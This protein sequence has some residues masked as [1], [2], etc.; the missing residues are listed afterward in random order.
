[1]NFDENNPYNQ[2]PNIQNQNEPIKEDESS[3][4]KIDKSDQEILDKQLKDID[5]DDLKT[6]FPQTSELADDE[7]MQQW[8]DLCECL[9]NEEDETMRVFIQDYGK[10][11]PYV[12]EGSK[13]YHDGRILN[14]VFLRFE[15]RED[16]FNAVSP[17][18]LSKRR[19]IKKKPIT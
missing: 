7:I 19:V 14:D 2:V 13:L 16:L 15:P 6:I 1:M 4:P 12:W 8:Q 9:G 5:V 11:A 10:E 3:Q 18:T 17:N